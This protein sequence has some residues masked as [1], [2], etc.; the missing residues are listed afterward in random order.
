MIYKYHHIL[1]RISQISNFSNLVLYLPRRTDT[2]LNM[3]SKLIDDRRKAAASTKLQKDAIAKVMEEVRSN[4]SKANKIITQ[5]LSGKISLAT[6]TGDDSSSPGKKKK[7]KVRSKSAPRL[8]P[9][10]MPP[11]PVFSA[12]DQRVEETLKSRL[13][14]TNEGTDTAVKPYISPYDANFADNQINP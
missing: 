14:G 5:A 2:M 11:R 13:K 3:K 1:L 12:G 10:E 7:K 4:A 6:L 9:I 8:E